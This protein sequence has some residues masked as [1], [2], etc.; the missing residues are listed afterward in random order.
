MIRNYSF[1]LFAVFLISF[2]LLFNTEISSSREWSELDIEI[3]GWAGKPPRLSFPLLLGFLSLGLFAE[4]YEHNKF[5]ST[6]QERKNEYLNP[7]DWNNLDLL[8]KKLNLSRY[9]LS[10][11]N[12]SPRHAR[13]KYPVYLKKIK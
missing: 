3:L 11:Y 2:N 12:I 8:G 1:F 7:I 5:V 6:F 13:F 4:I 10:F 9:L